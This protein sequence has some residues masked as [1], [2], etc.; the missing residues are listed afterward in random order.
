MDMW[1]T[2]KNRGIR[3]SVRGGVRWCLL[4]LLLALAWP[5]GVGHAN[6]MPVNIVLSYLSGV[7]NWGPTNA[8]G[9]AELVLREGEVRL[10]ATGLTALAGER[11]WIWLVNSATG[12]TKALESFNVGS[13]GVAKVDTVLK[14][15]IPDQG[16]DL[17]M[18]TVEPEGA[19]PNR[20]GQRRSIAGRFPAPPSGESRPAELPRT[21]GSEETA[22]QPA[23]ALPPRPEQPA[24][25]AVL[26]LGAVGALAA[27]TV[28]F[29]LGRRT[30]RRSA[31]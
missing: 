30:M 22:G 31:P 1:K 19:Q 4:A 16:W 23:N 9:I 21:G 24:P 29:V 8:T 6:G 7:S 3:D 14:N 10:T 15:P 25:L 18:L 27:G 26:G 12:E 13:D 2:R 20:P 11:Y 5:G 28:G 17:L